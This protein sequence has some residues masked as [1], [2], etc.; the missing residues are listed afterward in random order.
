MYWTIFL[1]VLGGFFILLFIVKFLGKT[2]ISQITP[3]DFISALVLGEIVGN[4]IYDPETSF[5]VILFASSIWGCLIYLTEMA[6]Q[7]SVRLRHLFEGKPSMI[8]KKGRLDW[9]E[10]KVNRLDIDQL[11]Q[12]LR[13][14]GVFSVQEVEY[15][16][17]ENNGSISVL[18]KAEA[19]Q[20]TC[21]DMKLQA[22]E[23]KMPYTIISDG[24]V[25]KTSLEEA[26]KNEE[27]LREEL[28]KQGAE[29]PEEISYAE[30]IP[31][32]SLFIQRY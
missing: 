6:T 22:S 4:A 31:G 11:Q 13:A 8:I 29:K 2:Q 20:P 19:D 30:Y 21:Q 10:L 9:A 1:E 18:R 14:K 23:R 12:L 27:W 3:F 24:D 15:A 28:Q 32:S 17:L 5:G 26:G 16:I 7:K 25:V